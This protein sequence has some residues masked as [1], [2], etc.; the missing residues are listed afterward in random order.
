MVL[1]LRVLTENKIVTLLYAANEREKN[2]T[3][4]LLEFLEKTMNCLSGMKRD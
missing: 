2:N 1:S 4:V 3:K